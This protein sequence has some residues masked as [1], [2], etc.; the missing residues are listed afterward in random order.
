LL[1]DLDAPLWLRYVRQVTDPGQWDPAF[2]EVLSW[3][4]ALEMQAELA[5]EVS[6]FTLR[7]GFESAL[8][9]ARPCGAVKRMPWHSRWPE[10]GRT[11]EEARR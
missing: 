7:A 5:P 10:H 1:C 11:W 9:Q 2:A 8:R 4:L 6:Q 3:K